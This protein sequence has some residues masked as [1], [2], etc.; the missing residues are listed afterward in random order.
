MHDQRKQGPI[1]AG[2]PSGGA[3]VLAMLEPSAFNDVPWQL[4]FCERIR[5]H[6]AS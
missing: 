3:V 2:I 4:P 5:V 6:V 1:F